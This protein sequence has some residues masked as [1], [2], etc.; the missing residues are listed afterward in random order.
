MKK[1]ERDRKKERGREREKERQKARVGTG[2]LN[3]IG[4]LKAA[5]GLR[6]KF[7]SARF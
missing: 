2:F 7:I 6:S 1:M 3:L 4:S 5:Y